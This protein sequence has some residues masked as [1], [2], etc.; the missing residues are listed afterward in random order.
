MKK[1]ILLLSV[2]ALAIIL[3]ACTK[4]EK[5]EEILLPFPVKTFEVKEQFKQEIWNF[6]GTVK[7]HR[8][9]KLSFQMPGNISYI[10]AKEGTK[11]KKGTILAKLDDRDF[12]FSL[13][14]L[15]AQLKSAQLSKKRAKNLYSQK[16]ATQE[17]LDKALTAYDVIQ[18]KVNKGLKDLEKTVLKA[19]FDGIITKRYMER[20]QEV[21]NSQKVILLQD[22]SILDIDFDIHEKLMGDKNK[23]NKVELSA[24]F[25]SLPNK[26]FPLTIKEV[27]TQ[28]NPNTMTYRITLSMENPKNHRILPGMSSMVRAYLKDEQE[29]YFV[30]PST[31]IFSSDD[32]QFKVWLF[33][34]NK[35]VS[36]I[37]KTGFNENNMIAIT[38]GLKAK[39]VVVSAGVHFLHENQKVKKYKEVLK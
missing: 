22:I 11:V 34:E 10:I 33:K 19:P 30:I 16:V 3:T 6:P 35:V 25:D 37:V 13:D 12:K 8:E 23:Q 4:V 20:F 7:A 2:I 18:A 15:K 26:S 27:E 31:A 36:Q 39:D 1:L 9:A 14:A 17:F 5:T 28:A 24:S 21:G 38:K 32:K 29:K